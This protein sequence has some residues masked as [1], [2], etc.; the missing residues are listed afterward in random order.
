M[1]TLY[2]QFNE[3][4]QLY[5]QLFKN[6]S[7]L[8]KNAY[9]QYLKKLLFEL[10][11]Y[12]SIVDQNALKQFY[13]EL[14]GLF[15]IHE[16]LHA[17]K[18]ETIDAEDLY[19]FLLSYIKTNILEA[20]K[21]PISI[22]NKEYRDT[23]EKIIDVFICFMEEAFRKSKKQESYTFFIFEG[24]MLASLGLGCSVG[25]L[26][27]STQYLVPGFFLLG[28]GIIGSFV[29]LVNIAKTIIL[30]VS[31]DD[32]NCNAAIS[33]FDFNAENFE[34]L[35]E[36]RRKKFFFDA[37]YNITERTQATKNFLKEIRCFYPLVKI[38]MKTE[39]YQQMSQKASNYQSKT[40]FSLYDDCDHPYN[41]YGDI[42]RTI[43]DYSFVK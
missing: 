38:I 15:I 28:L 3:E 1:F 29:V 16:G 32:Q 11:N 8:Q 26:K 19:L 31:N 43:S 21:D 33:G 42:T 27:D 35:K 36:L 25:L 4:V 41:L 37:P 20:S 5:N 34:K 30:Q 9:E 14:F 22:P 7:S 17:I 6:A 13:D 40:L 2:T 10:E 39:K 18:V 23:V 24:V 12:L